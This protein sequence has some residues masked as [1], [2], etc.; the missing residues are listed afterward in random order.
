MKKEIEVIIESKF[1]IS[2][3]MTIPEKEGTKL[4][5]VLLMAGSGNADR[6]GNM[7]KMKMNL[8]KDLADFLTGQ[9]FVTLR[10][11]KRG[12]N[13]STGKFLEA[14]I[15]D[16]IDDGA[17]ALRFLKDHPN[18]DSEKVV[19]LGHSEGA[20]MAP[21]VHKEESAAG[22][23]LLS[24]GAEA[25]K[26]LSALQNEAA[27]EEMNGAGGFKGWLYR[28]LKAVD[29]AR[30]QNAKI[31]KK[32]EASDKD[33]M[34][35]QGIRINAKWMRETLSFNTTDYLNEV[36]CPVLAVTG[37]KDVQVP[38]EHVKRIPE[39]VKGEAEWH[40][41]PGMNHIL[42]NY[43]GEHTMLGLIKEYKAQMGQPIDPQLFKVMG[44]WLKRFKG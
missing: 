9:G 12:I 29:K 20:L 13:K 7:K 21:A 37:E 23:I 15:S 25:S 10:Y 5:A 1:A 2:G 32:I 22:L 6:D 39:L 27:F 18:V 41:I 19:I 33:V 44:G 3:T 17:A 26:D 42:R 4:P 40:I 8:Y 31:F 14:G 35:I 24:G 28:T 30:K 43:E 36:D 16:F 38:P 11:D 34:R